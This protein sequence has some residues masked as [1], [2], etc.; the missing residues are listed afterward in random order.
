MNSCTIENMLMLDKPNYEN[1]DI[2]I[3]R[4]SSEP[5]FHWRDLFHWNRLS[6]RIYGDLEADNETDNSSIGNKTT[7][8]Y[9]Q[10]PVPNGYYK[11]SVIND[12]LK[13]G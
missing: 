13:S 6:F 7:N 3:I 9:K 11:V 8:I 2:T 12:V 1:H 4:T 5:H 10:N